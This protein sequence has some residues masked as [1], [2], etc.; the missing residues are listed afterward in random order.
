MEIVD[1]I[2]LTN[3]FISLS[4]CK[5]HKRHIYWKGYNGITKN[6]YRK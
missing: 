3:I 6:E 5:D 4:K 2:T 1:K